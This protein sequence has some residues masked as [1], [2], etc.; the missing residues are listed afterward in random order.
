MSSAIDFDD[1]ANPTLDASFVHKA[2]PTLASDWVFMDN[3]GGSLPLGSVIDAVAD[4]MRRWPV[5]L[6]ASY[7]PSAEAGDRV[8]AGRA[9]IASLF[10]AGAATPA[11]PSSVVLGASTSSLFSRLARGLVP[12]LDPGDEII[13]TEV[14]HEANVS[15][16]HRLTEA[17]A[18]IRTWPLN[19]DSLA[20]E[21]ADLEPLL[22]ERTRLVCFTH[23]SNILG[24]VTPLATI[25]KLAHGVGARVCVDGVAYAPH[26]AMA[27]TDAGVDFYAFS[28]YKVFGPHCAALYGQP[29]AL[30]PLANLNHRFYSVDNVPGKLEPGAFPYELVAAAATIPAYLDALG[31]RS[32]GDAYAAIAA[33]E[34]RLAAR[35]LDYL[36]SRSDARVMGDPRPG[37]DRLPT[38]SFVLD[39]RP[40]RTVPPVTDAARIGLRFG[41]FYAPALVRALGLA[42]EDGVI[43]VSLAH[44]NTL[45][46]VDRL[47][48]VLDERVPPAS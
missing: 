36:D 18:V 41:H 27:V 22:G 48:A 24:S 21:P 13:V 38:V 15:P 35:L 26:R 42:E 8:E 17:G 3:A 16:W 46:D 31:Q 10:A 39:G 12:L 40:S 30:A 28:L 32:G 6:G 43:R 23:A 44:Y 1:P 20:L 33:H 19:R 47:I 4:Y 29:A 5:Q 7:A 25:T 45:E 11:D 37:P 2:F 14:D 34:Q 9:A